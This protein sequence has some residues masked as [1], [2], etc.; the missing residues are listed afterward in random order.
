MKQIKDFSEDEL[1][2]LGEA[3][4]VSDNDIKTIDIRNIKVDFDG[5]FRRKYENIEELADSIQNFGLR[6]PLTVSTIRGTGEYLLVDGHRRYKAL[7]MLLER[8]I[9]NKELCF[10]PRVDCIRIPLNPEMRTAEIILT[11]VQKEGLHPVEQAEAFAKLKMLGWSVKKIAG[12]LGNN[13]ENLVYRYLKL[14]DAPERVKQLCVDGKISHDTV[15]KIMESNGCDYE[16]T[17]DTVTA[18]IA[19]VEET[20]KEKGETPKKVRTKNLKGL[21]KPSFVELLKTASDELAEAEGENTVLDDFIVLA[22]NKEVSIEELKSFFG[23]LSY[24]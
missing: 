20:T 10:N 16:A 5:N 17:L 12:L 9:E 4:K 3:K 21:K 23:K 22:T 11:G 6:Q 15:I 13:K 2:I 7:L 18:A 14:A 24:K 8:S 1:E 19:E